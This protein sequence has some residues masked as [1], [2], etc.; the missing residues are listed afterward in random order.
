MAIKL[1]TQRTTKACRIISLIL[2]LFDSMRA[3]L[4]P[5]ITALMMR[6]LVTMLKFAFRKNK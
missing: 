5:K 6:P 4:K 2:L 3:L 1:S